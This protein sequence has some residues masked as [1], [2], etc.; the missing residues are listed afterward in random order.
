MSWPMWTHTE[1]GRD[2]SPQWGHAPH[3]AAVPFRSRR[4]HVQT[5]EHRDFLVTTMRRA[6]PYMGRKA[7][8]RKRAG[9]LDRAHAYAVAPARDAQF[10]CSPFFGSPEMMVV[11]GDKP[12]IGCAFFMSPMRDIAGWGREHGTWRGV[13]AEA[14]RFQRVPEV[15]RGLAVLGGWAAR[16]ERGGP[17][18]AHASVATGA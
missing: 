11:P 16:G 7:T 10:L 18:G 9:S 15:Q 13:G 12:S 3:S 5:S 17:R 1:M 4:G 2:E 6:T 8:T 14:W